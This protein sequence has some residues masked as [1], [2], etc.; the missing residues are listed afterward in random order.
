MA[1]S[2]TPHGLPIIEGA[3]YIRSASSGNL[4]TDINSLAT[5]TN[6]A[7]STVKGQAIE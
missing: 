6:A 5:K 7:L 1:S 2:T 3:D 4:H